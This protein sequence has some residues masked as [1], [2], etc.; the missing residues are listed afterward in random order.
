MREVT[1][2]C[3][4]I[5]QGY[6]YFV[7]RYPKAAKKRRIIKKWKKRL[8]EG[9]NPTATMLS[10]PSLYENLSQD[11]SWQGSTLPVPLRVGEES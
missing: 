1:K 2:Q 10:R 5:L 4:M 9:F 8:G 6:K 7:K 3:R 11:S